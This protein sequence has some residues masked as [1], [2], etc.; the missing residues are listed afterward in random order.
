MTGGLD[1]AVATASI[2]DDGAPTA[3]VVE[4][5]AAAR[6]TMAALSAGAGAIHLALVMPHWQGSTVDG[7]TMAF[8]GWFQLAL[9]FVLYTK[10][11]PNVLL[12]NI[13][14]NLTLIG[15]WAISRT[16]GLP[17]GAHAGTAEVVGTADLVCVAFEALLVV[18]S[19]IFLWRPRLGEGLQRG[20]LAMAAAIPIVA[21]MAITT[22]ALAAESSGDHAGSEAAADHH[23][24][25]GEPE[26]AADS[27]TTD[28]HGAP[29]D[30]AC[31]DLS[32]MDHASMSDE[33]MSQLSECQTAPVAQVGWDERC[34]AELN[35][36]SYWREAEV[37]GVNLA[38]DQ[39]GSPT[40][41]SGSGS[42][43]MGEQEA[44]RLVID[45]AEMSDDDYEAWLRNMNPE[46]RDPDAPDD[47]GAGG[48]MGPQTWAPLTDGA[49]CDAVSSELDRAREVAMQYPTVAE[50]KAAGYS[51][52][53]PYVPGIAS[54]FMRFGSV[55]GV[56]D[57]EDPEMLLFDGNADDAQLVGLSYYL[58]DPGE[59]QPTQGF[60]GPNDQY[61]RHIGLCM[62]DGVVIGDTETTDE[63]CEALGGSKSDG[64]AGWMSHAWVV[65]GCE[66]PWG[67][68]SAAN[69]VLDRTLI[70]NSGQGEPCS[71]SSTVDR[72]DRT[73]GPPEE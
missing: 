37:S 65:P 51:M 54:H 56:F 69:P 59:E 11:S 58:L 31:A 15:L 36:A 39:G 16:A 5:S 6:V 45:L 9:A 42:E 55:D 19:G 62:R 43:G 17:W 27:G 72:Y 63:E 24:T 20:G 18:S 61:H 1:M 34:D 38:A 10:P 53:A 3:D 66:S 26:A 35:I 2:G 71:G 21:V 64:T 49:E 57:L 46:T 68:F 30:P 73:P 29:V 14:A 70:D 60:T 32:S 41:H 52:V 7:V 22:G 47:T 67:V 13:V 25:S 40:H 33:Q 23:A 8:A 48:H 28:H 4:Y 50:A 44:A 12:L